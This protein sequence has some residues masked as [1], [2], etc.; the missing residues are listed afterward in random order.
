MGPD[1]SREMGSS[2]ITIHVPEAQRWRLLADPRCYRLLISGK[3]VLFIY[4]SLHRH[5]EARHAILLSTDSRN[6]F[7]RSCR[8]R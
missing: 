4:T 7:H 5:K 6:A 1:K 2:Q 3:G 8:V